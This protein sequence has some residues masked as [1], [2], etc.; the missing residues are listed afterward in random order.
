MELYCIN[1]YSDC[2]ADSVFNKDKTKCDDCI[3]C[4]ILDEDINSEN[5]KKEN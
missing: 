4:T 1:P 2:N 5:F 3:F